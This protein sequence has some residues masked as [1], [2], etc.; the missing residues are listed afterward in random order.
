M[1][2]DRTFDTFTTIL[3]NEGRPHVWLQL[4]DVKKISK[5]GGRKLT[6]LLQMLKKCPQHW[7]E[8]RTGKSKL[9]GSF[10]FLTR[11]FK[12]LLLLVHSTMQSIVCKQ[13]TDR[14]QHRFWRRAQ[15]QSPQPCGK[16][17]FCLSKRHLSL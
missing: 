15:I 8:H 4:C 12:E 13:T 17:T 10:S 16:A 14:H 6:S 11:R 9:I 3:F 2:T 1:P 5:N 7:Q